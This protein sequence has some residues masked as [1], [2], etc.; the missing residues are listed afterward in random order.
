M[1]S[2]IDLWGWCRV[3][4][5]NVGLIL[6]SGS[7]VFPAIQIREN[8]FKGDR[9]SC[10]SLCSKRLHRHGCYGRFKHPAGAERRAVRRFYCPGC[11]HTV[12]VLPEQALPYR[13]LEVD[14]VQAHFD[15]K[16]EA[17]TGPDPPPSLT[18]AGCLERA[19]SRLAARSATLRHVFGQ[20]MPATVAS[21]GHLWREM[22]RT[23]ASLVKILH[24]L[25]ETRN[26]S[27]LGDYACLKAPPV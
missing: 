15:Q 1:V 10:P 19:W 11:G 7:V 13:P 26:I 18:E 20:L 2:H 6:I 14:R 12:S 3:P 21:A 25:A 8:S 23:Q 17:G 5:R 16:A 27:L 24:F 22:R 9:P 4:G